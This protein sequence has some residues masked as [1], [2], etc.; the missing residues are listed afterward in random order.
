MDPVVENDIAE[1]AGNMKYII[2]NINIHKK[3]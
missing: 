1:T 3:A 2:M